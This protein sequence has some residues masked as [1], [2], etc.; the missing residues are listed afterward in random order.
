[1]LSILP[2]LLLLLLCC[3]RRCRRHRCRRR[4]YFCY[5]IVESGNGG[6]GDGAGDNREILLWYG[7]YGTLNVER[8]H[9]NCTI[10]LLVL[11]KTLLKQFSH[12]ITGN[13][14]NV[15][16][17][18][19]INKNAYIR[20]RTHNCAG[21]DFSIRRMCCIL[22]ETRSTRILILHFLGISLE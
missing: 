21:V 16:P 22:N 1:M 11:V 4:Y 15:A 6:S 7:Q 18:A 2:L 10:Y 13:K 17:L 12:F 3:L 5:F 19:R 8:N 20:I 14:S 9:F